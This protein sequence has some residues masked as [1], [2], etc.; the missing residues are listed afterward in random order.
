MTDVPSRGGF[1][2]TR[3]SSVSIAAADQL[4]QFCYRVHDHNDLVDYSLIPSPPL[5]ERRSYCVARRHAVCV[6]VRRAA[7]ARHVIASAAKVMRCIQYSQV[8]AAIIIIIRESWCYRV[9]WL[10]CTRAHVLV[11]MLF[12]YCGFLQVDDNDLEGLSTITVESITDL[13]Y[14]LPE[15]AS[16]R[17]YWRQII[18]QRE[19]QCTVSHPTKFMRRAWPPLTIIQVPYHTIPYHIRLLTA[20][21]QNAR[22]CTNENRVK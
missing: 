3:S 2:S 20:T 8:A 16:S 18:I 13:I 5:S 14:L 15:G 17:N 7:T 4:L 19:S 1:S 12:I 21:C 6:C 9:S 11:L 10:S 22:M